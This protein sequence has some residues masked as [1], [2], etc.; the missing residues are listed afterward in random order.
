V[1]SP[2]HLHMCLQCI[3]IRFTSFIIL[4]YAPPSLRTISTGFTLL[5]SYM[6]TK[7]STIFAVLHSAHTPPPTGSHPW[8]GPIWSSCPPLFSV[9][10]D[11][12]RGLATAF[13]TCIYRTLIILTPLLLSLYLLPPPFSWLSVS[14]LYHLHPQ[15]Q[16][17]S[18]LFPIYYSLTSS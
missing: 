15:M 18:P 7:S 6:Y 13:H 16:C 9:C 14:S 3:L 5:F 11:C 17:I 8:T 12:S 1:C 10:I 2:W 4:P